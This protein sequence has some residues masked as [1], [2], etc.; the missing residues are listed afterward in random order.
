MGIINGIDESSINGLTIQEALIQLKLNIAQGIAVAVN[1]PVVTGA[2]AVL[3]PS[4][5]SEFLFPPT[6]TF[7]AKV[8]PPICLL[9]ETAGDAKPS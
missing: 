4:E 9:K 5:L 7:A 8:A 1:E 3:L 6:K 2:K